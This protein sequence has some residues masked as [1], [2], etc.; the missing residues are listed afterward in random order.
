MKTLDHSP[1]QSHRSQ[2][3]FTIIES[4]VA[5]IVVAILLS[6][7]S[8][9]IVFSVAT[10]V[11][12]R[13]V[14]LATQAARTYLDGVRTG[15]IAAPEAQIKLAT[16]EYFLGAVPAPASGSL[17]CPTGN[18]YCASP[19][20]VY[21]IDADGGGCTINSSK[22]FVIQG[23]RSY[24]TSTADDPKTGYRLG[25]RVYRADA[26]RDSDAL[27]KNDPTKVTQSTVTGGLGKRKAP[28]VEMTTEIGNAT[29]SYRELCSR[30]GGCQ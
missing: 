14:E 18:T 13:R 26:F 30:L 6:A 11:Q 22:D 5:I 24:L 12:A 17:N 21:C 15:A 2:S 23:F 28:L 19:A 9:A 7:I 10:R 29:N 3:G 1:S 4:L 8:P 20:S 25:M 27:L 16:T